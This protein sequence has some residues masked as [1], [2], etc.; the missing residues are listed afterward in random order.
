MGREKGKMELITNEKCRRKTF[1]KGIKGLMKKCFE[2][3]TLCGVDVCMI[4]YGPSKLHAY[5]PNPNEVDRIV[6][7]YLMTTGKDNPPNNS[8]LS[9]SYMEQ[10]KKI[11]SD[12]NLV[13]DELIDNYCPSGVHNQFVNELDDKIKAVE[14]MV[15]VKEQNDQVHLHSADHDLNF[16]D[17]DDQIKAVEKMIHVKEQNQLHA[18]HDHDQQRYLYYVP[19]NN[20]LTFQAPQFVLNPMTSINPTGK[21]TTTKNEYEGEN[22]IYA[23]ASS[24]NYNIHQYCQ[25]YYN[26]PTSST[27][28]V[29]NDPTVIRT[30][31]NYMMFNP[32]ISGNPSSSSSVMMSRY[33]QA[34]PRVQLMP[35]MQYASMPL[36]QLQVIPSYQQR[37]HGYVRQQ[38]MRGCDHND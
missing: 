26:N 11:G 10:N 28:P 5:P 22:E 37:M 16:D 13:T 31:E 38:Q 9:D 7:R 12:K 2:L 15:H 4:A 35:Y 17:S 24:S 18:E 33:S 29:F 3:S 6:Q 1:N 34:Q 30:P 20:P 25:N 36:L 21:M 14:E 27:G 19:S 23:N 32:T 8:D